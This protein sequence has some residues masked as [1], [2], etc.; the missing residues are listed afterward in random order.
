[1]YVHIA[2]EPERELRR[3]QL[4]VRVGGR[5]GAVHEGHVEG[6]S[7]LRLKDLGVV[8]LRRGGLGR[9]AG[10]DRAA[11]RTP[12][13]EV[14]PRHEQLRERAR[15]DETHQGDEEELLARLEQLRH[16]GRSGAWAQDATEGLQ[17]MSKAAR[18]GEQ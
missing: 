6:G 18:R 4:G 8:G 10:C 12:A 16:T 11:V 13:H 17:A 7:L 1:M 9:P 15:R 14:T 2:E 5:R 3:D